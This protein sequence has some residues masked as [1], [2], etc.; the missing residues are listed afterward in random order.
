M[1]DHKKLFYDARGLHGTPFGDV[2]ERRAVR[3]R[4]KCHSFQWFLENVAPD[5]YIPDLDPLQSGMI[6]DTQHRSCI[7]TMQRKWGSPGMYGCHGGGSQRWSLG[8]SGCV[9]A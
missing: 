6:T 2:S 7:D 1:D 3:E 5:M 9:R 8:H 4:N